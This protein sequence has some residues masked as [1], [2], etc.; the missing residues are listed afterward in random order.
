MR[1]AIAAATNS[2]LERGRTHAAKSAKNAQVS[3]TWIALNAEVGS[4][5][6]MSTTILIC[7]RRIG[8]Q[9]PWEYHAFSNMLPTLGERIESRIGPRP[10]YSVSG[11][12]A[13]H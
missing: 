7:V 3:P 6:A 9:Y 10:S 11:E 5:P 8:R 2:S 12:R 4:D 1:S 13:I